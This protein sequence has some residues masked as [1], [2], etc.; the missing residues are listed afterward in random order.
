MPTSF[1]DRPVTNKGPSPLTVDMDTA[2][3]AQQGAMPPATVNENFF[4][5][6]AAKSVQ[7]ANTPPDPQQ[8]TNEALINAVN[9]LNQNVAN[10]ST[11]MN[12]LAAGSDPRAQMAAMAQFE[13][14]KAQQQGYIQQFNPPEAPS[15][16]DLLTDGE[17]IKSFVEKSRNWALNVARA[18][19]APLAQQMQSITA[20]AEPILSES[21]DRAWGKAAEQLRSRGFGDENMPQLR[22]LTEAIAQRS[23]GNDWNEQQKFLMNPDAMRYASEAAYE[24]MGNKMPARGEAPPVGAPQG[25]GGKQT[26]S[27]KSSSVMDSIGKRLGIA[28]SPE[29]H[30]KFNDYKRSHG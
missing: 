20:L 26:S 3:A 16:D 12:N 21:R 9:A 4:G 25:R 8:Q 1:F 11:A 23:Y 17:A 24:Q 5:E 18:E 28:I 10:Q 30:E 14:A 13:Q 6:N 29:T 19:F 22:Q 2:M 15:T 7:R 27:S